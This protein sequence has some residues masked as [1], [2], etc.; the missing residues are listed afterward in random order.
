MTPKW[1]M[2]KLSA[3]HSFIDIVATG[4]SLKNYMFKAMMKEPEHSN[5]KNFAGCCQIKD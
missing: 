5:Q 1:A 3:N 2:T 4:E